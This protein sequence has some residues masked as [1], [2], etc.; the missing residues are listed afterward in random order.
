MDLNTLREAAIEATARALD[1]KLGYVPSDDS[2]EWEDEYRRQFAV[3]KQRHGGALR[4][5][6]PRPAARPAAAGPRAKLARAVRHAGAEALGGD[7]PRRADARDPERAVPR[8]SRANL[9]ARQAMGRYPRR[10]DR[11]AGNAPAP[12]IRGIPQAAGRGRQGA[13]GRGNAKGR[14]TRRLPAAAQ[15]GRHHPRRARRADR[16][17]R[18][19]RP[20]AA[21]R[22]TGRDRGRR[23]ALAGLRDERPEPAAGQG[24]ARARCRSTIT[25]SSA[26]TGWSPTSSCSRRHRS[27]GTGAHDAVSRSLA[28]VRA[29]AVASISARARG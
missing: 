15:G 6:A 20:G 1:A 28:R 7:D 26:T 29:A 24:E 19:L 13:R 9:D 16:C 17:Q 10:A 11:G 21:R 22:Q 2:D 8:L 18:A 27:G 23:T 25:R 12:A 3:L 14:R 5:A 4:P